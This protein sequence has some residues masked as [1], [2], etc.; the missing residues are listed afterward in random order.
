MLPSVLVMALCLV[1]QL[2]T[3]THQLVAPTA[4]L[5]LAAAPRVAP[6][7]AALTEDEISRE[8]ER[9]RLA[10]EGKGEV[11]EAT[12]AALKEKMSKVSGLGLGLGLGLAAVWGGMHAGIACLAGGRQ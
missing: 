9:R 5:R 3:R 12:A 4:S 8:K 1:P 2:T 6:P 11:A 7:R 10:A